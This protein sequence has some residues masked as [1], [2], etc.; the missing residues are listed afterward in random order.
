M[1]RIN[2]NIKVY[3]GMT[4]YDKVKE[5]LD[6]D[7]V[8][9]FIYNCIDVNAVSSVQCVALLYDDEDSYNNAYIGFK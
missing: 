8:A 5:Y 9:D 4:F 2:N 7:A 6:I 1:T 3:Q